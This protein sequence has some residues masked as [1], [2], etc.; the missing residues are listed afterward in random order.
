[1]LAQSRVGDWGVRGPGMNV[2]PE[3][4][5]VPRSALA[6]MRTHSSISHPAHRAAEH[7]CEELAKAC[8]GMIRR[9]SASGV[10]SGG[11]SPGSASVT[12]R[13]WST[14]NCRRFTMCG[15]ACLPREGRTA[16]NSA[17]AARRLVA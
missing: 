15:C 4:E 10:G 9:G 13:S 3:R 6:H 1:M 16:A 14:T 5:K 7:M 12:D 17:A 11:A 2:R 8:R